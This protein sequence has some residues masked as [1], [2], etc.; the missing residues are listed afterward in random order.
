ML[1]LS[2][3]GCVNISIAM[4]LIMFDWS[5]EQERETSVIESYT[6]HVS[7]DAGENFIKVFYFFRSQT[8]FLL[9]SYTYVASVLC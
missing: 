7:F 9:N 3:S 4:D 5:C 2:E 8:I 1:S 6:S